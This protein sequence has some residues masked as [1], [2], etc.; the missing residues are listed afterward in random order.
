MTLKR[1]MKQP[2]EVI[3]YDFDFR[4]W[5]QQTSSSP[6]SYEVPTVPGLDLS[7]ELLGGVV[8]V[9]VSGGADGASY[10]LTCRLTSSLPNGS[11]ATREADCLIHVCDQ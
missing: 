10:R 7:P 3:P 5:L 4:P 11:L 1:F 6:E 2:A 8:R 9:L